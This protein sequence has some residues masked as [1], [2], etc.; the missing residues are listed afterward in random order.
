MGTTVAQNVQGLSH[1]GS[2]DAPSSRRAFFIFSTCF[3]WYSSCSTC[4]LEPLYS[5]FWRVEQQKQLP[6][7]RIISTGK[8][9]FTVVM[10]VPACVFQTRTPITASSNGRT[11]ARRRCQKTK[12]PE[13]SSRGGH[14]QLRAEDGLF[15]EKRVPVD[16][17]VSHVLRRNALHHHRIRRHCLLD[18]FWTH[19]YSS[20]LVCWHSVHVDYTER[21]GKVLVQ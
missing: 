10:V 3:L 8:G 14:R 17:H 16:V 7:R 18:D 2:S 21:F 5:T 11:R 6:A 15:G 4:W 13:E 12:L 20:L 9:M 19:C 1:Q